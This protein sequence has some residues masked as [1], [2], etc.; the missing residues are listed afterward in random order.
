MAY[1]ENWCVRC[2]LCCKYTDLFFSPAEWETLMNAPISQELKAKMK[3]AVRQDEDGYIIHQC[4]VLV[5]KADGI[6][7]CPLYD[8]RPAVCRDFSEEACKRLKPRWEVL[9][10]G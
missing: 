6:C 5:R 9:D 7:E 2:G 8:Y 4:P 3:S 1:I 10:A